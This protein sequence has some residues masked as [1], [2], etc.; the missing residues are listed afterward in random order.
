[1]TL[2]HLSEYRNR[3][4]SQEILS[5]IASISRK[6]VRFMEVCGTH[7]MSIS[8]NGIRSLLPETITLLSGPGCP[9]C[10]TSQG[11]I[12]RFI[13]L[14][15]RKEVI[16]ATFGDLLRVPSAD[17]TLETERAAGADIRMV[18]ST[19][20]ALEIAAGN[21]DREVVFLGI[22][23][24][25][26]AP[27]IAAA[28]LDAQKKGIPNFSV[29]SAHKRVIPALEALLQHK[30][31]E[32][33]G[34]ICP[35]HVSVIIGGDAYR[36][37]AEMYHIPC[38]V[39]GFEPMDILQA[40]YMLVQ[41][42]E[43]GDA[44]V[45]IA[46][47]RGVTF[48]GNRKAREVMDRVFEPCDAVWRGIGPIPQSGYRFRDGFSAFD[49]EK[50]FALPLQEVQEPDGCACG[51]ILMGIKSPHQCGRF[52]KTCTPTH[53]VGPCMVSSEGTCAAYYKYQIP[54]TKY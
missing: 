41:Q 1:V 33:H 22:G 46:Y 48:E 36:P 7:T 12:D 54:N 18:Y 47:R 3:D 49:A 44:E 25:T 4:V 8:R 26:T 30:Q 28:V 16:V 5:R 53:P 17:A 13:R 31:V 20:D 19:L 9:V 32:V 50:K 51:E 45:E 6:P 29:L 38:V 24:E 42:I 11:E 23:F 43:S 35:G 2:K 15:R 14:S 52:G 27:T 40:F 34:F 37:L 10:V 21:P 39:A